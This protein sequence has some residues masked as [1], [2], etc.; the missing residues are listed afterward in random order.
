VLR[1]CRAILQAHLRI[2]FGGTLRSSAG[3]TQLLHDTVAAM[4]TSLPSS[5]GA[6]LDLAADPAT[7]LENWV[8]RPRAAD[9]SPG[10]RAG[11]AGLCRFYFVGDAVPEGASEEQAAA[12]LCTALSAI[13]RGIAQRSALTIALAGKRWG[14]NGI[15]PGIAEE[16][17]CATEASGQRADDPAHVRVLLIGEY[18]GMARE[19]VRYILDP[20]LPLPSSLTLAGQE[21]N[22]DSKLRLILRGAPALRVVAWQ[23]YEAL[24]R[25]L[26]G[27]REIARHPDTKLERLG[28]TVGDWLRMMSSTSIGYTRRQLV[29]RV[30]PAVVG[31]AGA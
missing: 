9:Y 23:R 25:C 7:P 12:I 16:V 8:A 22:A 11:L 20:D 3:F 6:A 27:L 24:A 26:A 18:G 30:L 28:I 1:V 31:A 29:D 13:R 5:R 4:A 14:S 21:A 15:M 17:L 19:L 2:A 10:L